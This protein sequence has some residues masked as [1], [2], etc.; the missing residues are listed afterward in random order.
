MVVIPIVMPG[1]SGPPI[2]LIQKEIGRPHEAGD[3][4]EWDGRNAQDQ[5][6][7]GRFQPPDRSG[8]IREMGRVS[9]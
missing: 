3:D 1:L 5:S 8:A 9:S 7:G 4:E 2:F 6:I